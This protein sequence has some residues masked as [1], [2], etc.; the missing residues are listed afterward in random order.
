VS[1]LKKIHAVDVKDCPFGEIGANNVLVHGDACLPNFIFDG[2]N[3]SGYIDLGDATV[4]N[5]EIDF[6]AVLWTLQNNFDKGFGLKF[7]EKYGVEN[8]NE[9]LVEK[10]RLQ[11][12]HIQKE[13]GL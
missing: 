4:G 1:V 5:P 9:E 12:E 8:A 2:E 6:S 13:W 10:L 7:L 3:F 11:Y